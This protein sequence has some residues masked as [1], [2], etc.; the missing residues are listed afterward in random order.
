MAAD[1][2][3]RTEGEG[4]ERAVTPL[5]LFFDLVF[6][7]ALTQVTG[8]MSEDPTWAGLGRGLLVLAALWWTWGAYAWL[9]NEI[10]PE[11]GSSRLA[12]LGAMGAMFVAALAVPHAFGD[13]GVLFGVAYLVVRLLHIVLF[14]EATPNM[15]VH[16][17][18]VRLARTAVPAPVLLVVAGFLDGGAQIAVWVVALAI[19]YSGPYVFGVRGFSVSADHFAE[20]YGLVVIIALG[21]SIVA[22]GIG[23]AGIELSASVVLSALL[24]VAL[25]SSLWWAYFDVV[26]RVARRKL[27]EARGHDRARL[28]R[29][30]FSYLH[31]PM[32]AGIVLVALGAKKVLGHLDEPLET[33]PAFALCGGVAVFLLAHDAIRLRNVGTVNSR[34]ILAALVILALVPVATRVDALAALALVTAVCAALITYETVRFREARASIRTAG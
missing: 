21:E 27:V 10:D 8:L 6:V 9:T 33:V 11:E 12:V 28:A 5:E 20:R 29:D 18:A 3:A 23:A 19:D 16:E 32:F 34:R 1:P 15:D 2:N 13:D 17:A 22:I 30:A 14:S 26:A 25:A 4:V 24:G 7:F 31:L